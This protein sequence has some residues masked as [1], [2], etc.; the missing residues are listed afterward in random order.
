MTL[1]TKIGRAEGSLKRIGVEI[2]VFS[3]DKSTLDYNTALATAQTNQPT[4]VFGMTPSAEPMT[5]KERSRSAITFTA[6]YLSGEQVALQPPNAIATGQQARRANCVAKNV[7][8]S[9]F[10]EPVG[11][12]GAGSVDKTGDYAYL[13]WKIDAFAPDSHHHL[14]P[15]RLFWPLPETHS[16]DYYPPN[17]LVTESWLNDIEE[18]VGSFNAAAFFGREIGSTQLVRFTQTE[19]N[20]S[21]H[22]FSYGFCY[23]PPQT[24]VD[25]GGGIV[26][27]K[28]RGCDYHWTL[29]G[30]DWNVANQVLQPKPK[31]AVVG[32]V[33]PLGD[34]TALQIPALS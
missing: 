3:S 5:V 2:T 10:L 6:I 8:R 29:D 18:L 24:D 13:K 32:R 27:P 4:T 26:I 16:R 33:W 7:W 15:G 17:A 21:D 22:E 11:V 19:R 28:I 12:Y 9:V 30:L 25:V 14:A 34:F 1:I 31:A 23:F 20:K